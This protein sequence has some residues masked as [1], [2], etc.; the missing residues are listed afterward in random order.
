MQ[1]ISHVLHELKEDWIGSLKPAKSVGLEVTGTLIKLLKIGPPSA[2]SPS[3]AA[4][5]ERRRYGNP[6]VRSSHK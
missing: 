2:A 5:F 1:S 4:R 6:E 3:A